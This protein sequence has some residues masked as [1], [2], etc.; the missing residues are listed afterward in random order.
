MP[1]RTVVSASDAFADV[2]SL[3]DDLLR[4]GTRQPGFRVV[5]AGVTAPAKDVTR[6]AGIGNEDL[7]DMIAPNQVVARY[8]EGDTVVLQGLH[9]TDRHLA[10]IANNLALALDHP[11][12]INGY[13]SPASARGLDLH[14]DYHDVFVVQLGGSKRWRIWEPIA[15]TVD[16]VKGRHVIAKPRFEELAEPLLDLTLTAGDCLYL[17]RGYPHSAET[18]DSASEHLTI[19]LVAITWQR[20]IRKAVDAE[21]AAGRLSAALPPGLLEPGSS[22]SADAP[23][24]SGLGAQLG[25]ATLR[26]W[27]AREIWRRQPATRLRP[28]TIPEL[29]PTSLTFGPG[30]LVWLTTIGDRAVLGL[31]DRVLDMPAEA[32]DFLAALLDSEGPVAAGDLKGLDH[33][34]RAVVLRRLLAEGVLVHAG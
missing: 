30:P 20:V 32:T 7:A 16:P 8:R 22:N 13:F 1:L 10:K 3:W 21:V 25:P 14:F 4:R 29:G 15:R 12:Q 17:P 6:R 19:G 23:D 33:A 2:E 11:V 27:M 34:S 18:T 28:R 26:H 9:H 31:G 24:L 5:R